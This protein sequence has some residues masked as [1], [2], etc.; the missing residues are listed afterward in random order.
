MNLLH[1]F[2]RRSAPPAKLASSPEPT[3]SASAAR[4][5]LTILLAHERAVLGNIGEQ[6]V[7]EIWT[8][9]AAAGLRSL[10]NDGRRDLIH[11]CSRCNAYA[12]YDFSRFAVTPADR[13][14]G[15]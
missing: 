5:R 15:Q 8:G 12:D 10:L 1:L 11:L 6:T 9:P 3:R 14:S 2:Q 13:G 7:Q 4:D